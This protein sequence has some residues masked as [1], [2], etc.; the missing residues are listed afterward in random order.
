MQNCHLLVFFL[1]TLDHITNTRIIF[2]LWD[3]HIM[4]D[5][6]VTWHQSYRTGV[7]KINILNLH[8]KLFYLRNLS[9]FIRVQEIFFINE[10]L[11][12]IFQEIYIKR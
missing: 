7:T 6:L 9:E 1:D 2:I 3:I 10:I 8:T 5:F 11:K 12:N 4:Q